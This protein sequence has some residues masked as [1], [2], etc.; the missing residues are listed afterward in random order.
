L[1]ASRS[2]F[3]CCIFRFSLLRHD[4]ILGF[5]PKAFWRLAPVVDVNGNALKFTWDKG[6]EFNRGH[7]QALLEK[8]EKE[9]SGLYVNR[10]NSLLFILSFHDYYL[11]VYVY[12]HFCLTSSV[13]DMSEKPGKKPRPL[14][15]NTVEMLKAASTR[16]SM[17]PQ[18]TMRVAEALYACYCAFVFL[19]YL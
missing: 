12:C 15:L 4:Q 7:A 18:E 19:S 3:C 13:L 17:G 2:F 1:F 5:K 16:L 9:G 10:S 6:R 14:P 8:V 11:F